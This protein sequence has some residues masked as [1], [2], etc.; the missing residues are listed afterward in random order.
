MGRFERLEIQHLGRLK[1]VYKLLLEFA[2]AFAQRPWL[3]SGRVNAYFLCHNHFFIII[4]YLF[5]C[6][7]L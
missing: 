5:A 1:V 7:R 4:L 3:S 6:I 2:A